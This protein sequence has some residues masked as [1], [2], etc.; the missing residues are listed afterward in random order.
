MELVTLGTGTASP[1]A[2]RTAAAHWVTDGRTS[3][4][5]DCGPGATH[6]LATFGLDWPS[7][8]HV[9][10]SHFHA[11]HVTELPALI[12]ALQYGTPE[13]RKRPLTIWGP[14]GL[15]TL[16]AGFAQ[17]LGTWVTAPPD[18]SIELREV[19]PAEPQRADTL[20]LEACSTPHTDE[21]LAWSVATADARLVYT[22]DTGPSPALASWARGCGLLLAECSLPE[23]MALEFHLTPRS[24]GELAQQ[25]GADRLVLTHFYP[26]V[27]GV[28]AAATAAQ[29]FDGP[30]SAA[31]DGDRFMIEAG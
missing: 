31:R 29:Y 22:G 17:A 16:L 3:V 6:R 23:E 27:E 12:F 24:A 20:T 21:S 14:P 1:T 30:V 7:L 19:E 26:P 2:H 18:Y 11:D 13:P 25:A 9:V 28:D 4:L 10:I 15:S 5:M 8:D